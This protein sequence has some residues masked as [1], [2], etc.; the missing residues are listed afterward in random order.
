MDLILDVNTWIY[1]MDLGELTHWIDIKI[2]HSDM[3][4]ENPITSEEI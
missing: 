1:P 2:C 3:Q 4:N